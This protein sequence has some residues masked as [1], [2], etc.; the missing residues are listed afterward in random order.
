MPA[1]LGSIWSQR[2]QTESE[3][4]ITFADM[5]PYLVVTEESLHDV[6]A[7]LAEGVE[8]DITK[9]RPNIVLSGST[10]PWEEDFWGGLKII[11]KDDRDGEVCD[12]DDDDDENDEN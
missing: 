9:F 10:E 4:Y 11:A 6:S 1:S 2:N 3:E 5:A 8:M 12:D 7:R